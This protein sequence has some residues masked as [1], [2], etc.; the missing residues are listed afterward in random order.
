M[1]R[2]FH[3]GLRITAATMLLLAVL[4]AFM[5]HN[6]WAAENV[7]EVVMQNLAFHPKELTVPAGTTVRFINKDV[8]AHNVVQARPDQVRSG[9]FGFESAQILSGQSWEYTFQ[10]PGEYPL[11]C[12]TG[13]HFLL[14]MT[15]TVTVE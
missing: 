15:M 4:M 10:T 5:P 11:L 3:G 12:T 1:T 13:S 7:V 6:V 14:G 8:L 2:M 9:D